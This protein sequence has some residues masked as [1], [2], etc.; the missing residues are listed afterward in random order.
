MN[1]V[2]STYHILLMHKNLPSELVMSEDQ[3]FTLPYNQMLL[4]HIRVMNKPAKF[5][6]LIYVIKH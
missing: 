2:Y 5:T 4:M 3:R 6:L 1:G